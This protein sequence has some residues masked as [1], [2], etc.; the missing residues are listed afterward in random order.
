LNRNRA[1]SF[2]FFAFSRREPVS[3]PDQVRGVPRVKT[4]GHVSLENAPAAGDIFFSKEALP[5][6]DA[7]RWSPVRLNFNPTGLTFVSCP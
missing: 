2:C 4:Q 7:A 1:L 3:A 6:W 5:T